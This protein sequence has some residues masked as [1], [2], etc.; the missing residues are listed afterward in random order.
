METKRKQE[1]LNKVKGKKWVAR[2]VNKEGNSVLETHFNSEQDTFE[3][4]LHK[5][6][7]DLY[8]SL[9]LGLISPIAVQIREVKD[10]LDKKRK[11]LKIT[12]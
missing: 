2:V 5:I 1:L 3:D 11:L 8:T 4:I 6:E 7:L 9:E 12:N 10:N